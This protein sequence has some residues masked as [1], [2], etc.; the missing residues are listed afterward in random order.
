AGGVRGA[1]GMSPMMV[2]PLLSLN[3]L[4]LPLSPADG[5]LFC[6]VAPRQQHQR[7]QGKTLVL[8]KDILVCCPPALTLAPGCQPMLCKPSIQS[9]DRDAPP[10]GPSL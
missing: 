7:I 8:V 2:C 6:P 1:L 9:D 10:S 3:Q 5:R 4:P